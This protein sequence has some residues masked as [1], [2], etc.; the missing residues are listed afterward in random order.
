MTVE[1]VRSRVRRRTLVLGSLAV[2]VVSFLA[3]IHW[4]IGA[5]VLLTPLAL[6]AGIFFAVPIVCCAGCGREGGF[7]EVPVVGAGG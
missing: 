2:G 4:D 5:F 1:G 6:S 3:A 7:E